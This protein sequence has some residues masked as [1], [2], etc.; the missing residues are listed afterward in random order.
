MEVRKPH[1]TE[2]CQTLKNKIT[3]NKEITWKTPGGNF[4]TSKVIKAEFTMPEFHENKLIQWELHVAPDLGSYDMII[5]RDLLKFL[6][7]DILFSKESVEWDQVEIPFKILT[8]IQ[9]KLITFKKA[10]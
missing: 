3:K 10:N 1:F 8:Q 6:K 4:N 2:I 7:I 9:V 5:G